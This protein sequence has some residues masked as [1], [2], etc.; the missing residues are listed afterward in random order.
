MIRLLKRDSDFYIVLSGLV[1]ISISIFSN[2]AI[3]SFQDF[4]KLILATILIICCFSM[5]EILL[6]EDIRRSWFRKLTLAVSLLL[7]STIP[8]LNQGM[9]HIVGLT[10]LAGWLFTTWDFF[11]KSRGNL[12]LCALYAVPICFLA[13]ALLPFLC[14]QCF[15]FF[16]RD[17]ENGY[18]LFTSFALPGLLW[19]IYQWEQKQSLFSQK[20]IE[21]HPNLFQ[22]NFW[23]L[24]ETFQYQIA[25]LAYQPILLIGFI[26]TLICVIT[27]LPIDKADQNPWLKDL[28]ASLLFCYPIHAF[29]YG[30]NSMGNQNY[31]SFLLSFP[32]ILIFFPY[33]KYLWNSNQSSNSI[34]CALII[35]VFVG[36]Y[37]FYH[38]VF[39]EPK[40]KISNSKLIENERG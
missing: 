7:T 5:S 12:Y 29:V 18:L 22:N 31:L 25:S 36:F 8:F 6:A 17:R 16:Q 35:I 38:N 27:K 32:L 23:E 9:N 30:S 10:C 3:L 1:A 15:F 34:K 33:V 21:M 37:P 14:F 40:R 20:F 4:T 19:T 26:V 13:P 24:I 2:L 28:T 39:T 11:Y